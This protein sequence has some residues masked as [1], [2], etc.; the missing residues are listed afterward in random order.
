MT[1]EWNKVT[2]YSKIASV[3]LFVGT[4]FLGFL[5]GTVN[6]EKIYVEVPHIVRHSVPSVASTVKATSS[7]IATQEP[8][9]TASV[10]QENI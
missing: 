5:L 8:R 4:F 9:L 10:P 7:N 2:W 3:V 1:I 6:V